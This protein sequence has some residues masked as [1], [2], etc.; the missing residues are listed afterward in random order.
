MQCVLERLSEVPIEVSVYQRIQCG[1]EVADPEQYGDQ[2]VGART[3]V[4]AQRCRH[5]PVIGY[6]H[7]RRKE[8]EKQRGSCRIRA[9][10]IIYSILVNGGRLVV[11]VCGGG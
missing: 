3:G 7:E 5:V 4:A 8:K 11:F 1:I 6:R 2:D 10:N 9:P